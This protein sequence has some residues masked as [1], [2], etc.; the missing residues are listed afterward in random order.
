MP[1]SRE[2]FWFSPE[3]A[4]V[5]TI[6]LLLILPLILGR[7]S[8]LTGS[9]VL[10]GI[11]AAG[12]L[13]WRVAGE[14]ADGGET[15]LAPAAA[16]GMLIA[17]NL[18]VYFKLVL[19]LFA[20]CITALWWIG[21]ADSERAAPEFFVLLLGS[22]LGMILMVSSLNLLMIVLAI[23]L[24]SLP[25]YAIVAF[26]KRDRR[27]GE[28]SLKY[29][30]FGSICA[31]IMLYGV[32]LLYGMYQTLSFTAI[33]DNVVGDLLAGRNLA[34]VYMAL[35]C[36]FCGV[37]FKIS[38]VPFHFWCPDAFQ[39]A[40]IEVTTWLSV[41]SKAAGLLLLLR[42]VQTVSGAV[43]QQEA[44]AVV[45]PLAWTLGIFAMV[46]CTYG[47][48]AAY[49]QT[50]VKRLLAYSSIAHAGYMLMAV[51]IF[52]QPGSAGA[53]YAVSAVLVYVLIYLFMNL[54]AFGITALVYWHTGSDNLDAFNGLI[55]RAPWLAVPMLFCLMSLVGLPPFAGFVAKYW[56][57]Y[58]LASQG[59]M[60]HWLYWILFLVAVINTLVSLYFY[61]RVVVRMMLVDDGQ[62][63]V[64]AP[65]GGLVLANICGVAVILILIFAGPIK[66]AADGYAVNLYAPPLV[67]AEADS[68]PE[69]LLQ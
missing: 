18:S 60:A 9:I 56:I 67:T 4:I 13:T 29:A 42:L 53:Q 58:A 11:I 39:G 45:S 6:A 14:V 69:D 44:M 50:S 16:S 66:R 26:D 41:A 10:A 19:L 48:L 52:A 32:S 33:A 62:E 27:A 43:G 65:L 7:S 38:A 30:V 5:A 15:G 54:G 21:S 36:F 31:A 35:L 2:L 37:G 34:T 25:S 17:D 49:K 3:L 40:R 22:A 1:T 63:T 23:E 59:D 68:A 55:R 46:T 64:R 47:N 12:L 61:L 8:R 28:V 20:A 57:L 24:A 51:A